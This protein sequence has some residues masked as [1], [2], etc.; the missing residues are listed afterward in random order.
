MQCSTSY[1]DPC[2]KTR[3]NLCFCYCKLLTYLYSQ[4]QCLRASPRCRV[5]E[6]SHL[7]HI[8]RRSRRDRGLNPGH[9][10][11]RQRCKPPTTTDWQHTTVQN[12]LSFGHL[13]IISLHEAQ[14]RLQWQQTDPKLTPDFNRT[15]T[16]R[17]EVGRTQIQT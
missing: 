14:N 4:L 5:T 8:Y 1:A 17:T 3:A 12:L 7:F 10:H 13:D 11:G 16:A 2:L 9:L 6:K 15:E